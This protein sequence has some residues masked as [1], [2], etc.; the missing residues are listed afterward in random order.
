MTARQ[1]SCTSDAAP[2]AVFPY[3]TDASLMRWIGEWAELDPVPGGVFALNVESGALAVVEALKPGANRPE[4]SPTHRI[5]APNRLL[6]LLNRLDA[7]HIF[8][9]S[10]HTRP[11]S[12]MM[13]VAVLR[14]A[15][16]DRVHSGRRLGH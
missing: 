11:D 4:K 6:D 3:L 15:L 10:D 2:E 14:L 7:A 5:Y 16:G 12:V 9:K 13:D 8:Y 1:R